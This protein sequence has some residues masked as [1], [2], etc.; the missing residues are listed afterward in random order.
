MRLVE[1]VTQFVTARGKPLR[2]KRL[3]CIDNLNK[4]SVF[5]NCVPTLKIPSKEK[6]KSLGHVQI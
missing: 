3:L 5:E 1:V 6:A 2:Y 4:K